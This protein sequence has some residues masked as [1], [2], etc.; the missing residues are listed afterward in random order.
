MDLYSFSLISLSKSTTS[1]PDDSTHKEAVRL[2]TTSPDYP[3]PTFIQIEANTAEEGVRQELV[4]WGLHCRVHRFGHRSDYLCVHPAH[5]SLLSCHHFLFCHDD[6][7]NDHGAILHTADSVLTLQQ[8]MELLC[9]LGYE[10]A[11]ILH[12]GTLQD[13]WHCIRFL[14]CVPQICDSCIAFE[15]A[16]ASSSC[17]S[18]GRCPAICLV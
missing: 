10:R 7:A 11:V 9:G 1:A 16:L 15:N 2:Y 5:E 17:W 6:L 4:A 14:N 13:H 12:D 8:Q 3:V 18:L